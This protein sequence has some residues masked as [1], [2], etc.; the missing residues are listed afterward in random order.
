MAEQQ[1]DIK[2]P[3]NEALIVTQAPELGSPKDIRARRTHRSS[4]PQ[5][6]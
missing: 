6:S 5:P 3:I 4:K 1:P 2:P